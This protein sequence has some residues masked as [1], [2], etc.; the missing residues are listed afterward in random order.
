MGAQEE[1]GAVRAWRFTAPYTAN[2]PAPGVELPAARLDY[3]PDTGRIGI[4]SE[5]PWH[6]TTPVGWVIKYADE[7]EAR[8]HLA[9]LARAAKE[10]E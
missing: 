3:R 9:R 1:Q 4:K 5:T 7:A 2:P 8:A 10:D 6:L